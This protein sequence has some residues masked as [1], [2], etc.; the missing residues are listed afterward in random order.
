MTTLSFTCWVWRHI[1]GNIP[2]I[3]WDGLSCLRPLPT[4]CAP[5]ASSVVGWDERQQRLWLYVLS[6]NENISILSTLFPAPIQNTAPYLLLWRKLILSQPKPA[7]LLMNFLKAILYM[8]TMEIWP[9]EEVSQN[10]ACQVS[11]PQRV[12]MIFCI[13]SQTLMRCRWSPSGT[14]RAEVFLR[15]KIFRVKWT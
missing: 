10:W 14:G 3:S 5:P 12:L 2:W 1:F 13:N 8:K 7:H 9:E 11:C 4:A 6:N 15:K